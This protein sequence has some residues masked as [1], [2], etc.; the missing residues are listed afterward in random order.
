LKNGKAGSHVK[1]GGYVEFYKQL[2]RGDD[3]LFKCTAETEKM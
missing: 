1:N 3:E 2:R